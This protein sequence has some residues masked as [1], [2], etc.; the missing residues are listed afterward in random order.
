MKLSFVIYLIFLYVF[1]LDEKREI[2]FNLKQLQQSIQTIMSPSWPTDDVV[3]GS[4]IGDMF[5]WMPKDHLY[6]LVF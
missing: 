2:L 5:I 6:V 3:T 1:K 4:N